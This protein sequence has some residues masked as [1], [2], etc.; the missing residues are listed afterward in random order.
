VIELYSALRLARTASRV[1]R[2]AAGHPELQNVLETATA[3]M[4]TAL[5]WVG[6]AVGPASVPEPLPAVREDTSVITALRAASPRQRA[7]RR[8]SRQV[9]QPVPVRSSWDPDGHN[10][11]MDV[12]NCRALLIEIIRRAAHDY[13]LY[14]THS[15]LDKKALAEDAFIWLFEEDEEHPHFKTRKREGTIITSF[16]TICE[17]VDLDPDMVRR[18]IKKMNVSAVMSAG[19]PAERRRRRS[20]PSESDCPQHE[21]TGV[22]LESLETMGPNRYVANRYEAQFASY[23]PGYV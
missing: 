14:R 1:L 8:R 2:G 13:V 19:R 3:V 6:E 12:M 5:G 17:S 9:H 23:T 20:P 10:E 4:E 11:Q 7:P 16:L 22:K 15:E 21:L 18:H